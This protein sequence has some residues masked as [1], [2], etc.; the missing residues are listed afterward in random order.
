MYCIRTAMGE[1]PVVRCSDVV[2]YQIA[3][4]NQPVC[5]EESS[6]ASGNE[7]EYARADHN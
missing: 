3:Y 2:D 4:S 6:L 5:M 1:V 7:S